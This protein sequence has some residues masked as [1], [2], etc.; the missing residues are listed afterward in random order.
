MKDTSTRYLTIQDILQAD[1]IPSE[2]V[3]VPEWNG[4]VICRGLTGA[5]RDHLEESIIKQRSGGGRR[6][7]QGSAPEISLANFRAKL[8]SMSLRDEKGG[9]LFSETDVHDLSRK[10]AKVL[11]RLADI[12][13]RL[14]GMS[15]D[16]VE[17]LVGNSSTDPSGNSGLS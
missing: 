9:R 2:T 8:V 4:S 3:F 13:R 10:S 12:I 6:G 16:D 11:D 17:T 7:S 5:E 14:S 1:D 15:E